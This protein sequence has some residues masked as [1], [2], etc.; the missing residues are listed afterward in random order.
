VDPPVV[1]LGASFGGLLE[2][3]AA[4]VL[5]LLLGVALGV[6]ATLRAQWRRDARF[7]ATE[8]ALRR[9]ED[10]LRWAL[11]ATSEIVWD[12]DLATDDIYQPSWAQ[13][14]GWPEE[15]TPR[16]GKELLAF[17]H[18]EDLG[19]MRAE[20][21]SLSFS[22]RSKSSYC[23]ETNCVPVSLV[24]SSGKSAMK[25]VSGSKPSRRRS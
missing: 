14:Y 21:A 12:W 8:A 10:R 16:T 20:V 3:G 4:A 18:P 24:L 5:A 2:S 19:R 22:S 1:S 11:E 17:I 7:L 25:C 13:T 9:S 15:R 23:P 6:G